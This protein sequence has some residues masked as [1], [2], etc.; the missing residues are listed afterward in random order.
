MTTPDTQDLVKRLRLGASI[1]RDRNI[2]HDFAKIADEAADELG[3]LRE[4]NES[5][6]AEVKRLAGERDRLTVEAKR[7]R[8]QVARPLS[9]ADAVPDEYRN[10]ARGYRAGWND[11]IAAAPAQQAGQAPAPA[12]VPAGFKLVP[13]EPTVAMKRACKEAD[14]DHG[15]Y[16]DWIN[17]EWGDFRRAWDAMLAAAPVTQA[18]AVKDERLIPVGFSVEHCSPAGWLTDEANAARRWIVKRNEPPMC[19]ENDN[20]VWFGPTLADAVGAACEALG[21]SRVPVQN[22]ES[23]NG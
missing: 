15:S 13:I 14:M 12:P 22:K 2:N 20:R 9:E 3:L 10:S 11:A 1:S 23:S 17:F 7:L 4:Q 21:I 18:P 5:G 16:S 19:D 8:A 6:W